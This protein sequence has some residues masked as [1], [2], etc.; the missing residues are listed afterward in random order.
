MEARRPGRGLAAALAGGALLAAAAGAAL[1]G[2][3]WYAYDGAGRLVR[4]T[5]GSG[6]FVEFGYDGAGNCLGA[7]VRRLW[8]A[9]VKKPAP[10]AWA[11]GVDGA[12]VVSGF[13]AD[14]VRGG[15]R[16]AGTLDDSGAAPTGTLELRDPDTDALLASFDVTGGKITRDGGGAPLALSLAGS[17]AEGALQASAVRPA[18]A[19]GAFHGTFQS[20]KGKLRAGS[21][22]R[23]PGQVVLFA[24]GT[25]P[26]VTRVHGEVEGFLLRDPKGKAWGE[27]TFEGGSWTVQAKLKDGAKGVTVKAVKG[28][29]TPFSLKVRR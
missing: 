21:V 11:F 3:T 10:G 9:A 12:G 29:A 20:P 22:S 16:I 25:R 14:G 4:Q 17:G 24:E 2:K 23:T 15:F 19:F 5:D 27:V 7:Q 26:A 1:A 13:G 8:H 18:G 28:S 6:R